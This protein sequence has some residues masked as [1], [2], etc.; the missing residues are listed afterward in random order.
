MLSIFLQ[1][2]NWE[3][4]T[5]VDYLY[6]PY[7][8]LIAVIAAY[9]HQKKKVKENPVYKYF[10]PGL[11][12]KIVFALI[13]LL[14]FTE[15][16]G[17]GDTIDYFKGSVSVSKLMLKDPGHFFSVLFGIADH[18]TSWYF[19][20]A[21]TAWPPHYLWKG[22]N[23]RFVISIS[24]FF[25]TLG[26]RAFMP[27][28][29]LLAIF[30]YLGI[31]KLF[32]LFNEHFPHVSKHMAIAILFVPSVLFW[33]SGMM[34]DTYTLAASAWIVYNVFMIFI[35]KEK[36]PINIFL[37]LLNGIIILTIKPYIFVALFPG[38]V[39]W[40]FYYRIKKI[41]SKIAKVFFV[42]LMLLISFI[43]I[44]AGL[45]S[46]EGMLGDYSSIDKATKKAQIIQED[47]LREEQYGSNNYYIGQLDGSLAGLAKLAP[48]AVFSG[49]YRPFLWE[50]RNPVM[51]ISGLENFCLFMLSIYLLVKLKIIGFFRLIF[52][53]P[54]LIFSMLFALFFLFGVGIAST[55]F[56]ALVRYK[57]P[58]MPFLIATMFIMLAK[59]NELKK[60][61]AR[62][63]EL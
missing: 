32:L 34:K 45:S 7:L 41:K 36:I 35:K 12:T 46:M 19:F 9:I 21:D 39:I 38:I 15:Y 22:N 26:G 59:Y 8:V 52:S 6:T 2:F 29:I 31:W 5:L 24:S 4:F 16:Y 54:L 61:L 58:A 10:L 47:L 44:S 17:Y 37:S 14:I 25:T 27:A 63:D 28:T 55:N 43:I 62:K 18:N 53:D 48:L 3:S 23:T 57:I 60:N 1:T 11:V 30:S 40:V 56:G 33:G 20:D 49:M 42:P 51:I 13:F 50:A